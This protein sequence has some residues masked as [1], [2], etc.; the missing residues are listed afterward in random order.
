MRLEHG[1]SP[2]GTARERF[3]RSPAGKRRGGDA[4][5]FPFPREVRSAAVGFDLG[6]ESLYLAWELA[7][8]AEG[9]DAD[10]D[11]TIEPAMMEGGLMTALQHAELGG[12]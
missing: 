12:F 9:V 10:E 2:H 4:P 1:Y 7:S 6:S 8:Y 11:G 5:S 3:A